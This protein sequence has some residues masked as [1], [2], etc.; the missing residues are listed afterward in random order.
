MFIAI[1]GVI[2]VPTVGGYCN[3]LNVYVYCKHCGHCKR[4]W[5]G[6]CCVGGAK[7][8]RGSGR[9]FALKVCGRWGMVGIVCGFVPI[10]CVVH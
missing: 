1:V 5:R 6:G 8:D 9:G 10:L 3:Y 4:C 7:C 2:S